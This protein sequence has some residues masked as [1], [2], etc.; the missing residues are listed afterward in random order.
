MAGG[1][2]LFGEAG[3]HSPWMTWEELVAA[4]PDV[5]IVA[6][7]GFDLARTEQE[8]YWMTDRPAGAI[9]AR[10]AQAA[11]IWRTAISTSTAPG[12]ASSRRSN[13]RARFCI[14]SSPRS[15]SRHGVARVMMSM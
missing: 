9:C 4:D 8:M 15:S 13:A 12:R 7:C 1:V 2:N 6:P 10:C 3:Q 5:M 14:P 11:S